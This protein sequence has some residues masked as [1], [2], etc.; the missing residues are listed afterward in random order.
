M[1]T[2]THTFEVDEPEAWASNLGHPDFELQLDSDGDRYYRISDTRANREIHRLTQFRTC[3]ICRKLMVQ[4]SHIEDEVLLLCTECGYW[5]G[6]GFREWNSHRHNVPLRGVVGR[7]Q[8]IANLDDG[9]TEYLVSHLRRFPGQMAKVTPFRAEKFVA[10]LLKD[11]LD[12]EV[13]HLGGRKDGGIDAFVLTNDR[14]QTIIQVKWRGD[15]NAAESVTTVR[16]VAGTLLARG[17]PSGIIVSTRKRFSADARAEADLVSERSVDGIGQLS[18][19]LYDYHRILDM[20]S[21]SNAKLED[22]WK[23][24][25]LWDM[26]CDV[27][28]FDGAAKI[29]ENR[30]PR[31]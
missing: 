24:N 12:C 4:V 11:Y 26:H 31:D 16:E 18:L 27:C 1:G 30:L 9:S 5:G 23:A 6:R 14:I 15:S 22:R 28:V 13:H 2:E 19:E 3:A 17:V 25:D 21:I 10:D 8:P 7:Y 29:P 20:L